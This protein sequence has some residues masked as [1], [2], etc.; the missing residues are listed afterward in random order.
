V[1]H[2]EA[3]SLRLALRLAGTA[4][5]QLDSLEVLQWLGD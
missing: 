5:L 4:R 2:P 1:T 3:R